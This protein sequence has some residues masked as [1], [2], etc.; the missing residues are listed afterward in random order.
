MCMCYSDCEMNE[1]ANKVCK[2]FKDGCPHDDG[3]NRLRELI[4]EL[5]NNLPMRKFEE[6]KMKIIEEID[7]FKS[8]E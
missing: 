2:C 8:Y 4:S 5:N 7:K 3:K 6:I 1:F